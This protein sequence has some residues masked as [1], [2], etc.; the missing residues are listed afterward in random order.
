MLAI[1]TLMCSQAR[2]PMILDEYRRY[3][4]QI[5]VYGAILLDAAL[6]RVLLVRV[7]D[8]HGSLLTLLTCSH[9]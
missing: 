4:Q 1:V 8:A 3:K 7:G 5:P 9:F 2:L 6:E